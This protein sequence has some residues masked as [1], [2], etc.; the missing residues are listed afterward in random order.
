MGEA[1]T[2]AVEIAGGV[3]HEDEDVDSVARDVVSIE[4]DSVDGMMTVDDDDDFV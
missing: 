1:S 3:R 4:I 2:S